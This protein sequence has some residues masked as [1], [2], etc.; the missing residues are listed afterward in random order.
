MQ[1]KFLI[2]SGTKCVIEDNPF[3][4][5]KRRGRTPTRICTDIKVFPDIL[6]CLIIFSEGKGK[7]FGTEG[8]E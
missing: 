1:Y 4:T 3:V 7:S 8:S 6:I 5:P 2:F